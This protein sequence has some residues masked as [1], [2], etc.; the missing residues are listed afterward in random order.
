[1]LIDCKK[2]NNKAAAGL[3][4]VRLAVATVP[5]AANTQEFTNTTVYY[6]DR[7]GIKYF[8]NCT[9]LHFTHNITFPNYIYALSIHFCEVHYQGLLFSVVLK[10][11]GV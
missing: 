2:L 5:E 8:A 3:A 4:F 7:S 10:I 1:M 11:L 6:E 9:E